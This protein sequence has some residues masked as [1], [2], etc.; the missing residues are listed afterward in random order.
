[1]F[2]DCTECGCHVWANATDR[3]FACMNLT[4]AVY[5]DACSND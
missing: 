3:T 2:I 1:M 5:C 4:E